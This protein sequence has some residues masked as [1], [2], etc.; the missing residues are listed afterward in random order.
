VEVGLDG[1]GLEI[2][3]ADTKRRELDALM[4]GEHG[5][6]GLGGVVDAGERSGSDGGDGRV[7]HDQPLGLEGQRQ[8]GLSDGDVGP[9]VQ[10]EEGFGFG[11]VDVGDGHVV[12]AAGNVDENVEPAGC[13][14]GESGDSCDARLDGGVGE[15]VESESL[16]AEILQCGHFGG[17]VRCGEDSVTVI[18]EGD[19]EAGA[20]AAV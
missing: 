1:A 5:R 4:V 9:D 2:D 20:K 6:G 17:V 12:A 3:N 16:N 13:G 14:S 11:D 7:V 19:G 18:V 15:D 8:K 10:V